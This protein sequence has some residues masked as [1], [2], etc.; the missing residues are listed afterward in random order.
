[1]KI[2][3]KL[4]ILCIACF[5]TTGCFETNNLENANISTTVYPIEYLTKYLYENNGE[6]NSIYPAGVDIDNYKLSKKQIKE[7]SKSDL[8]IYNGLTNEKEIA[9]ELLNKN[10]NMLIIDVSYGLKY[11]YG[12]EEL[13]LSPNNFLMLGKNIKEYLNEYINSKYLNESINEKYKELEETMSTMDAELRNIAKTAKEEGKSATIVAASDAFKYLESYGFTVIS[14]E[15]ETN[16]TENNLNN[17]KSNFKNSKYTYILMF[18]NEEKTDLINDLI[19]SYKANIISIDSMYA[20]DEDDKDNNETY[21]SLMDTYI[22][23]I[24]K[25]ILG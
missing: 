2:S 10:K 21:L 14:L 25:I 19:N 15:D 18:E 4:I 20:L 24:R 22:D 5:I 9:K 1:M 8:F 23:N 16:L 12:I 17:I 13:W 7:Y 11:N 3:K 6:V